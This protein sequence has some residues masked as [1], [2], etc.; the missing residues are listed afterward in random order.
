MKPAKHQKD[1]ELKYAIADLMEVISANPSNPMTEI[2]LAQLRECERE[3]YRRIRVRCTRTRIRVTSHDPL[4]TKR[5]ARWLVRA[6]PEWIRDD[7]FSIGYYNLHGL[8]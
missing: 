4:Q 1:A 8:I 5:A 6:R 2:Y 3:T 7:Q